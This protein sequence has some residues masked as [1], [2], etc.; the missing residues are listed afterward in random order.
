MEYPTQGR[1]NQWSH[2]D[3]HNQQLLLNIVTGGSTPDFTVADATRM[4]VKIASMV[5]PL[6]SSPK[7]NSPL[8]FPLISAIPAIH[9]IREGLAALKRQG[10][11]VLT[12]RNMGPKHFFEVMG[13]S[14]I[15]STQAGRRLMP[16]RFR[17]S[18]SN[19]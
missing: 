12:A 1:F 10:T 8:V 14:L 18:H 9:G 19:R 11:D 15:R 3:H 4:G 7:N 13:E 5:V 6:L 16:S 2:H 17:R